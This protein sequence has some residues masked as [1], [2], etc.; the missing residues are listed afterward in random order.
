MKALRVSLW[1]EYATVLIP[2]LMFAYKYPALYLLLPVGLFVIGYV[3]IPIVWRVFFSSSMES[4][5]VR[6]TVLWF[7][8]YHFIHWLGFL[9]MESPA[10][11]AISIMLGQTAMRLRRG[12]KEYENPWLTHINRLQMH[13]PLASYP[14]EDA[15]IQYDRSKSPN[16]VLLNSDSQWKFKLFQAPGVVTEFWSKDADRRDFNTIKVP[17]NWELEGYSYPIY[18]NIKHPHNLNPPYTPE[19]DN[20]TGCYYR[21]FDVPQQWIEQN[22]SISITFHGVA[23][24]M[25]LYINGQ[26]VGMSKD[27]R[28]PAEFDITKLV[29]AKD[30]EVA[31]KVMRW[32]DAC[33]YIEDQDH[34]FLSGIHR[35]VEI[36]SKPSR[37]ISDFRVDTT[38]DETV[39][40]A[41]VAVDVFFNTVP[42]EGSKLSVRLRQG[43]RIVSEES[44]IEST[45]SKVSVALK[46]RDPNLW[47]A[48]SPTLYMLTVG[49]LSKDGSVIEY[50]SCRVG[51]REVKIEEGLLKVNGKALLI[52]GVN[53]HDHDEKTGKVVTIDA[54]RSDLV[55][56]KQL[57]FNAV[58]TSHYPNDYRFYDLCDELGMYVCDEANIEAHGDTIFYAQNAIPRGRLAC[59]PAYKKAIVSRVSR[60]VMRDRNHPSIILW[61]LGNEASSGYNFVHAREWIRS[62]DPSRPVQYEGAGSPEVLSDIFCPMY[63]SVDGIKRYSQKDRPVILCEYAHAMGN[64][65]G[66]LN[67]YWEAFRSVS[68][69][70]GGFIWDW[71][72]QGLLRE[73]SEGR[74]VYSYGGD[75]GDKVN[76]GNFNINGIIF[77]DRSLHP[78][79]LE[80]KACQQPVQFRCVEIGTSHVI[81]D[82]FNENLFTDIGYLEFRWEVMVDGE[83]IA[84]DLELPL[85]PSSVKAQET[86]RVTLRFDN[87]I[88]QRPAPAFG[89]WLNFKAFLNREQPWAG[90][91]H[92]IAQYQV[93]VKDGSPAGDLLTK[94]V[95]A[96]IRRRL[97]AS[98]KR[99]NVHRD[100]PV[101]V[102]SAGELSIRCDSSAG[103]VE[104][105]SYGGR[106]L[107]G[108]ASLCLFRAPTDNDKCGG[109]EPFDLAK[110]IRSI[111]PGGFFYPT[112]VVSSMRS[113]G[114]FHRHNEY[115]WM[116]DRAGL[117]S[118]SEDLLDTS[119]SVAE[120]EFVQMTSLFS[121]GKIG[122]GRVVTR[123]FTDGIVAMDYEVT[124]SPDLPT[125]PRVGLQV[126]IPAE[127]NQVEVMGMGPGENY[128]DRLEA[129]S[130]G[131]WKS[132]VDDRYVPYIFPS[133]NGGAEQVRYLALRNNDGAGFLVTPSRNEKDFHAS[134][135]KYSPGELSS[136]MHQEEVVSGDP[137]HIYLHLDHRHM[138]VGG[139]NSWLPHVPDEYLI[140]PG[141]FRFGFVFSPLKR[142]QKTVEI[143]AA[144][145]SIAS[146]I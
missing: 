122:Q 74:M 135:S 73:D 8:L 136:A 27:S 94:Q 138:G 1:L 57:N 88:K 32:S 34:W 63:M 14:S 145:Y 139:E 24:C 100:D 124:L 54:M 41:T 23:S 16:V 80:A 141:R 37:C 84:K 66:S 19:E 13:V 55:L 22:R 45:A 76:D 97:S 60:M 71:M 58:R 96:G 98:V 146:K 113:M 20:P 62:N 51:L 118:P 69:L 127:F 15:A 31:V 47:S 123:M 116:W 2:Y 87:I 125:L 121:Y 64:S 10:L 140:R 72:D 25:F 119:I 77:P 49:Y 4:A 134:V 143:A 30:N 120:E 26:E 6:S 78:S 42:E 86:A 105:I 85:S 68:K 99:L 61:S 130:I 39:G 102:A 33:P 17:S 36:S 128:V 50:E 79:A 131:L 52:K 59:D 104:K 29:R 92:M 107:V 91:G 48:E 114:L 56:M 82:I 35:D 90:K 38:V 142:G 115:A 144:T 111:L 93:Q 81:L 12:Q 103:R 5:S 21:S 132:T 83:I 11:T 53:R 43:K 9:K 18:T 110:K 117:V 75:Y 46:V 95:S 101:M 129:S 133:E 137:S 65:M 28:L 44:V 67:K 40:E 89:V 106:D 109:V 70:Q 3:D 126:K 108:R 112:G 7:A